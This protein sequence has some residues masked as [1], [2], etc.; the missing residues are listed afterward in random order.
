MY[1]LEISLRMF[2]G[3]VWAFRTNIIKKKLAKNNYKM[4]NK[5]TLLLSVESIKS[6]NGHSLIK[7]QSFQ[8]L[9]LHFSFFSKKYMYTL[10]EHKM[11]WFV[12]MSSHVFGFNE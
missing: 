10:N 8:L 5:L 11:I 12:S 1:W 9:N 4:I 2:I 3:S 6:F 7:F